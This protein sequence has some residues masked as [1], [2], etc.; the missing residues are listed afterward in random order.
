MLTGLQPYDFQPTDV[1]FRFV[2][3]GVIADRLRANHKTFSQ[4]TVRDL[5]K[6]LKHFGYTCD[7]S[8]G[9]GSHEKWT[10]D[11]KQFPL[12]RRDPVS[13]GVFNAFLKQVGIDRKQYFA[14]V[15][16]RL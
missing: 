5:E 13:Q 11:G 6:A 3:A 4:P 12:P 10:K 16:P 2:G 14:E 1:P 15:H 7:P 9:K 8:G